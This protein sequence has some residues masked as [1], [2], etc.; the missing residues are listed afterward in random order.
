MRVLLL[1]IL[2]DFVDKLLHEVLA[3]KLKV[4]YI[5]IWTESVQK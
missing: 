2:Q 3:N 5:F 1:L 4:S